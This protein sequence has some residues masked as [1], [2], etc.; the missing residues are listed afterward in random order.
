[1]V[2]QQFVDKRDETDSVFDSLMAQPLSAF[3]F[4]PSELTGLSAVAI[5]G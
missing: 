1:M 2:K 4:P 3:C 5:T